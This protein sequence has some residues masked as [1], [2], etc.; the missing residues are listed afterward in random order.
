MVEGWNVVYRSA[1]EYQAS[2]VADIL[3]E[4]GLHPVMLDRK[5]DEFLI[6]EVEVYVAPEEAEQA[7]KLIRES[8]LDEEE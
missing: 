8:M 5:D 6:G 2:L 3:E 7:L 4:N 1:H